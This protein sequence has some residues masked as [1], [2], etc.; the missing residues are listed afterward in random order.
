MT[1]EKKRNL[2][3]F[4]IKGKNNFNILNNNYKH[5]ST[6]N[7]PFFLIYTHF[8]IEFI[9]IPPKLPWN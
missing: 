5:I 8:F 2:I 6:K 9:S 4:E 7:H 3:F 1:V